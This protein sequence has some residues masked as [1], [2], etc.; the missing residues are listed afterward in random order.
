MVSKKEL[1]M[2]S[3]AVTGWVLYL[4]L[5]FMNS[6]PP[7]FL[8]SFTMKTPKYALNQS[9]C[10]KDALDQSS[11]PKRYNRAP[12]QIAIS[13]KRF[14]YFWL[15]V[16]ETLQL[17][18]QIVPKVMCTSIRTTMS[19]FDC[20]TQNRTDVESRCV[21]ARINKAI[22]NLELTNY[23]RVILFRDPFERLYS[24]YSNS[25]ANMY[26]DLNVCKNTTQCTFREWVEEM[27]KN[28]NRA[29]KN[30]HFQLQKT[31]A[32]FPLMHY[33]YYL[34]FSSKVDINFFWSSLLKSDSVRLN[35]SHR[36]R[37]LRLL[38][39][40]QQSSRALKTSKAMEAYRDLDMGTIDMVA[41][42][43][44]EDLEL[45]RWLLENGTPRENGESTV[46][47]YYQEQKAKMGNVSME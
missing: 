32:Q 22:K 41:T 11:W 12:F 33:H 15:T 45:W 34:R 44:K 35:S 7:A 27:Y 10:P 9:S 46:Y 23:T 16:S 37:L 29:F 36:R 14:N 17:A 43:Y 39:L 13:N 30:E 47:D 2:L 1:F 38:G 3:F 24:A 4:S 28:V 20:P 8:G 6:S 21:E 26:I 31:I 40:G 19:S 5:Y 42:I 18:V 25:D